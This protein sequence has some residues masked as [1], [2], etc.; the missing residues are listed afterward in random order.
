MSRS[1]Y[2]FTADSPKSHYTCN[3]YRPSLSH[4]YG[5]CKSLH[6]PGTLDLTSVSLGPVSMGNMISAI[7]LLACMVGLLVGILKMLNWALGEWHIT[8]RC[9]LERDAGEGQW[10]R[11][12]PVMRA[13][14]M[15]RQCKKDFEI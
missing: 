14:R 6:D 7:V 5:I 13:E 15:R 12:R 11:L 10:W 3:T 8:R 4:K 2:T 1:L 9:A